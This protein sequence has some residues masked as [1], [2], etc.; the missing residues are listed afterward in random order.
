MSEEFN[1][2][3][4]EY[5]HLTDY[6]APITSII[7]GSSASYNVGDRDF[8]VGATLSLIATI[9]WTLAMVEE[10]LACLNMARAVLWL[11]TIAGADYTLLFSHES[12][13]DPVYT[14]QGFDVF[15]KA[16]AFVVLAIRLFV[17][18]V[19][20]IAGG[21]YLSRTIVV[22]GALGKRGM[23]MAAPLQS[24]NTGGTG[25]GQEVLQWLYTG[26]VRQ[27]PPP[28]QLTVGRR[29]LG[30]GGAGVG[31]RP[32][33]LALLACGCAYWPLALEPSAMTSRHPYYCG[34]PHCCGQGGGFPPPPPDQSDQSG[35]NEILK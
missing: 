24:G 4:Q 2:I 35:E 9:L 15:R 17:A 10:I 23:G 6:L 30:G 29:P 28:P 13:G 26:G 22:A 31:T 16:F 3:E 20:L 34:H 7:P 19:L 1:F 33:W 27:L 25:G 11:P 32:W 21:M 8:T 18:V 12:D 5:A 14:I